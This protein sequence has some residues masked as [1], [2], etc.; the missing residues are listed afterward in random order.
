MLNWFYLYNAINYL[1][2]EPPPSPSSTN[3]HRQPPP[4]SYPAPHHL[5]PAPIYPNH[6]SAGDL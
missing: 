5:Q 2:Y 4:Q 3:Y 1:V 6:P